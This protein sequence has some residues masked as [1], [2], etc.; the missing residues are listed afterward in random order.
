MGE[1]A[2]KLPLQPITVNNVAYL[3][4]WSADLFKIN[5]PMTEL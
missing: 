3:L 2:V 5:L 4:Y 1:E